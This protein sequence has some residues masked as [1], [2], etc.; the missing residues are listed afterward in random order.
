MSIATLVV[1]VRTTGAASLARLSAQTRALGNNVNSLT[2]RL[3]AQTRV[4]STVAGAYRGLNGLWYDANGHLIMQRN[5][6]RTVTTAFGHLV[7]VL[8]GVTSAF[9]SLVSVGARAAPMLALFAAKAAAIV[10]FG[11]PLAAALFDITGAIQLLAPAIIAAIAGLVT[12]KMAF[13][14]VGDAIGA[15]LSGDTEKFAEALKKIS[16]NAGDFA[17]SMVQIIKEWRSV[18]RATQDSFFGGGNLPH[19]LRRLSIEFKPIAQQWLPRI[20]DG[21]SKAGANLAAFLLQGN[22][23]SQIVFILQNVD[24]FLRYILDSITPLTQ[25]FLDI[26]EVAAPSLGLIGEKTDGLATKFANWIRKMK[27]SGDLDKWLENAKTTLTKLKEIIENLGRLMVATFRSS[28]EEGQSMLDSLVAVTDKLADWSESDDGQQII[29]VMAK[30][31][32]AI[33][34]ISPAIGLVMDVWSVFVKTGILMVQV[35]AAQFISVFGGIIRLAEKAARAVGMDGTADKLKKLGDDVFRFRDNVNNALGGIRD[36]DVNVY[37]RYKE[38]GRPPGLSAGEIAAGHSFRG[39]ARG[40]QVRAGIPIIVGEKRPELFIPNS[41]GR[42][43]PRVPTATSGNDGGGGL[44]LQ[45]NGTA[46]GMESMFLT[47]L[48]QQIRTG[49]LTLKAAGTR[50]VPA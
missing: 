48:A 11:V 1:A 26:A 34:A 22:T 46:R 41:D 47:W 39:Y 3:F 10:A 36:Q 29:D 30:I 21:F 37:V 13:H 20:A 49:Q 38:V 31:T 40:G 35:M 32:A 9:Q 19:W 33:T 50:V 18:Q 5:H 43:L 44:S 25:A 24:R 42:I 27:E 2:R 23:K 4:V 45:Y 12:L 7:N 6:L 28:R 8:G 16:P 17:K 15:G 14:G